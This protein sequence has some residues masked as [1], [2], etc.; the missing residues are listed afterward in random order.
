MA[1]QTNESNKSSAVFSGCEPSDTC[2]CNNNN[3]NN[4]SS[5]QKDATLYPRLTFDRKLYLNDCSL[6]EDLWWLTSCTNPGKRT[7]SCCFSQ[8]S[9]I[10][11]GVTFMLSTF[12]C[13]SGKICFLIYHFF[14]QCIQT[15]DA[16]TSP[17]DIQAAVGNFMASCDQPGC[18]S[19]QRGSSN[20]THLDRA[21]IIHQ[22]RWF[23]E[24]RKT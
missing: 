5:G 10:V 23:H 1:S 7:Q 22:C 11:F 2:C 24:N 3:N 21:K 17:L 16:C 4:V 8:T 13:H 9:R 12:I 15:S 6:E 14:F 19:R 18:H 20:V